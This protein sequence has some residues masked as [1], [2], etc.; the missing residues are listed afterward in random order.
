[1]IRQG[2]GGQDPGAAMTTV[3]VIDHET[4]LEEA[5]RRDTITR[6]ETVTPPRPGNPATRAVTYRCET[7]SGM[8]M[9]PS[10]VL[11]YAIAGHVQLFVMNTVTRDFAGSARVRL[12]KGALRHGIMIRDRHCQSPG[13]DTRAWY[14]QT[15][16]IVRHT[17]GGETVPINADTRCGP[18]HR[19]KTRLET[20]G[21]WPPIPT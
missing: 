4:M 19:H 10:D 18:C 15:D 11:D 13:C 20:L 2:A 1:M 8:P 17:D 12:F 3:V 14:C 21:L 9:S 7:V 5:Q 16:H 6:S